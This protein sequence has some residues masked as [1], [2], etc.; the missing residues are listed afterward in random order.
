[1]TNN[2][3]TAFEKTCDDCLVMGTAEKTS[4]QICMVLT[5]DIFD[6]IIYRSKSGLGQ[7]LVYVGERLIKR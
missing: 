1:M 2:K 3:I 5:K 6:E 7:V 4:S